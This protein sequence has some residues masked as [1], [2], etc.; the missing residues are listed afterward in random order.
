MKLISS[1]TAKFNRLKVK[2]TKSS[3]IVHNNI[4]Y[5]LQMK[6]ISMKT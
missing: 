6:T 2:V 4:K 5:M 3:K 1:D